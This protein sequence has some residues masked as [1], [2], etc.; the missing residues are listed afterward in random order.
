ML[1]VELKEN[2]GEIRS[3]KDWEIPEHLADIIAFVDSVSNPKLAKRTTKL[4]ADN[5]TK[6]DPGWV[7][8]E[9]VAKLYNVVGNTGNAD[10]SVGVMEYFS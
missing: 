2:E 5:G 1:Q 7:N 4:S 6:V 10:T 8:D 9:V 3:E